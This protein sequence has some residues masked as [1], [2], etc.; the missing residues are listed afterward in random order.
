MEGKRGFL[1][2]LS[3][4]PAIEHPIEQDN[5]V[6]WKYYKEKP[7]WCRTLSGFVP[8][9]IHDLVLAISHLIPFRGRRPVL[10]IYDMVLAILALYHTGLPIAQLAS[11]LHINM[12]LIQ[13]A[14][15][16]MR[17]HLHRVL[18]ERH[19]KLI[20]EIRPP[21]PIVPHHLDHLPDGP[22]P[23][24]LVR[25]IAVAIDC[26]PFPVPRPDIGFNPGIGY[27]D[28]H[29]HTYADKVE[30]CVL[31]EAPNY[32][33][34]W[35]KHHPGSEPDIAIH[36]D[37]DSA[38]KYADYLRMTP[39]EAHAIFGPRDNDVH[40]FAAVY[41]AGYAGSVDGCPFER[42]IISH[43]NPSTAS[44]DEL[45]KMAYYSRLRV[46]VEQWFGRMK[47]FMAMSRELIY[48]PENIAR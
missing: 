46:V 20:L 4:H 24:C 32:A 7:D 8:L 29:H 6:F 45:R 11:S 31:C 35:S 25:N 23:G 44:P 27:Y 33:V 26:T 34:C 9:F 38:P 14:I 43:C 10:S 19:K 41:D 22:G 18:V 42:A 16:K 5:S 12:G 36:R 3:R 2:I 30:V 47:K 37:P 28:L 48:L 21:L 40:Y 17:G 1:E 13:R 15:K 39:S